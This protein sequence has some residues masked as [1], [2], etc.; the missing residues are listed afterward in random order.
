[1]TL[2]SMRRKWRVAP[3]LEKAYWAGTGCAGRG[4]GQVR[5]GEPAALQRR[6]LTA[7]GGGIP[8]PGEEGRSR[9][10]AGGEGGARRMVV[11]PP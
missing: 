5:V 9:T 3:V 1:L 4:G 7:H 11:R 10:I 6:Y 8:G 2:A